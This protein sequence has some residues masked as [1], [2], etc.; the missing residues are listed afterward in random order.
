MKFSHSLKFNVVP[1]WQDHYVAYPTLKK[2]VYQ[3]E[4]DQLKFVSPQDGSVLIDQTNHATVSELVDSAKFRQ[5]MAQL[6]SEAVDHISGN[7]KGLKH[8][9]LSKFKR[10]PKNLVDSDTESQQNLSEPTYGEEEKNSKTLEVSYDLT[11]A[12][13]FTSHASGS[14][15][16]DYSDPKSPAFDA[17]KVFTK[18][19][20]EEL[21]KVSEFYEI[22]EAE[23]YESYDH[24]IADLRKF[25][26]DV[27]EEFRF[28]QAYHNPEIKEGHQQYTVRSTLSR[29]VSNKSVF[30]TIN[31]ID[32]DVNYDLE[33]Q[34]FVSETIEDDEEDDDDDDDDDEEP[35]KNSALLSHMDFNIKSQTKITLKKQSAHLFIQLSELKSYI[36]LNKI[37]FTKICKKF[38][39]TCKYAIKEDF[40]NNF[41]P[42][43]C[44]VFGSDTL[45]ELDRR[46]N[47]M[48]KV[49]AFL[50]GRL[51]VKTTVSDLAQI[52]NELKSNLREHIVWERNTVWKDMLSLEKRSYG[53][54]LDADAT[55]ERMGDEGKKSGMMYLDVDYINLPCKVFKWER[56]AYPKAFVSWQV[57]K[58]LITIVTFVILITVKTFNDPVQGRCLAVLVASA[59]L[60]ASEA[61]PLYITSMLVPLLCV[62]CQ[63][64][65]KTDGSNEPMYAAD[66][67]KYILSTMWSSVIMMLMG[68][69]TLAAAL[70]KYNVAK[71]VSSWILFFAGT[72][73]HNVLLAIMS[74]SL[75]LA[76]WISNVAA[77][78]LCYSLIQPVLRTIPTEAPFTQALVLGVALASNVAGMASPIASPQ[79]VIAISYMNPNPGWGNWFAVALPV[80][81]I[82][83]ICIW[84]E[85]CLTFKIKTIKLQKYTPIKDKFTAKQW[86]VTLVTIATIILWC[87]LTQIESTFGES[88]II[89]IIPMILFFGTGMLKVDD[90]NNFPWGIVLLA[91]GGLA[92]GK[93]VTSSGLLAT[94]ATSLQRRIET[95]PAMVILI[96]FGALVLVFATFVSHTVAALI[97]IPLV[98]KVGE[99]LPTPH[100][101]LL[102]MGTALISSTAMGLPTSGFPNVTAISMRDEVGKPYLTVNT[103]ITRGVPASIIAYVIIFTVGYGIMSSLGW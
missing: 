67:S 50:S 51:N 66:A 70:S 3:L 45:D 15:K 41:L 81:I 101:A 75:F 4:Q 54:S 49:Y 39:K 61:L 102:I 32:Q 63:I 100:P 89:A 53:L 69:F 94:I 80:S 5:E 12:M 27:E 56:I 44:R 62:T 92:L 36:E 68:G 46:I 74:V 85:L 57:L 65:K 13:T 33:K 20:L 77:P 29:T 19:L 28:T 25:N 6:Q 58:L 31:H 84:G 17:L 7:D 26:I 21:K 2:Q 16:D 52:K 60:W 9:L 97:I 11:R 14:S 73:P 76:M 82:T 42:L 83:L 78:V 64:I 98:K 1:E 96:I 48:V 95:Y 24:L 30:D 71:V 34:P 23:I 38:D 18:S 79:N 91:M 22:K 99:S 88:G 87:V 72:K 93:A 40:V 59:M 86:Y 43:N 55:G 103:F 90:L 8:R 47:E 10:N 37:A 35:D